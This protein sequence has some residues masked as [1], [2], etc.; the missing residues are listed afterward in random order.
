MRI[1]YE[2]VV[3]NLIA[4]IGNVSSDLSCYARSEPFTPRPERPC[5][6]CLAGYCDVEGPSLPLLYHHGMSNTHKGS[7]SHSSVATTSHI[8]FE[9]SHLSCHSTTNICKCLTHKTAERS[10]RR[11][12]AF[13]YPW[14]PGNILAMSCTT[15]SMTIESLHDSSTLTE[16][17]HLLGRSSRPKRRHSSYQATRHNSFELDADTIF[18]KVRAASKDDRDAA[19]MQVLIIKPG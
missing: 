14:I 9:K 18:M 3:A 2:M 15:P 19:V 13:H 7:Q 16:H 5:A 10:P 11:R 17:D 1:Q 4:T 8:H 6:Q 12:I